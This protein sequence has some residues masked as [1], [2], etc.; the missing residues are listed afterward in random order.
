MSFATGVAAAILVVSAIN[1]LTA[2]EYSYNGKTLGTVKNQEDVLAILDVV[3][4]QL[5]KE[6]NAEVYIDKNEDITFKKVWNLF[7]EI[8]TKEEV[9]RS[10]TYMQ[11]M[12][13]NGYA[14]NV[15]GQNIA[16]VESEAAA[17]SILEEVKLAYTPASDT[18]KY[19]DVDFAESIDILQVETKLGKL[20]SHDDA[21]Y[22]ILTGAE[23]K[24]VHIVQKGETF[25]TIAASY[26]IS[27]ADLQASNPTINPARLSIG[28]EIILTQAVPLLTVQTVE[29]CTYIEYIP[30]LTTYEESASMY[31][32]ET[33]TK[34]AGQYGERSVTSK[35]VRNNGLEVAKLELDSAI[36]KQPVDA[37]IVKGTKALPAKKGTGKFIYPVTGYRLTS[38]FG[39]RW[40][41]MHYGIDLACSTGTKIRAADGGTVK[42]S[43][44]S[45]SY[46][47]VVKIDHGGG[48]VTVYAHCSKLFVKVGESVYQGQHIANVGSTGRS[49]GPHCHF[50]VQYLG[51]QKNPLN[52]L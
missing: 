23:E 18:I 19:E 22:K 33:S 51:V 49:T 8:D 5:S 31:Q 34:R 10:L 17:K 26:G 20:Y 39:Q 27:Q 4:E 13:V 24:K 52:Y 29:I 46:G 41:R 6:H 45:G 47:Y 21:L 16:I 44:Y 37:I 32:G 36:T 1:W 30:Y 43:G 48:Y 25:S 42:F 12:S 3:S 7:G 28:Q 2:Y 14:I 38:T 40:G 11:D 50:E 15:E 35:V 9:L